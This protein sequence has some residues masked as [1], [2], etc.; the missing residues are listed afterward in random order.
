MERLIEW[1]PKTVPEDDQT[2]I[3]HADYRLDNMVMHATEPRVA[4]VLDWELATLGNPLADFTYVLMQ[5]VNGT[6]ATIPDLEAHGI[7]TMEEYVA[8]YCRLTGRSGLPDLNWYFAY[9]GFRLAGILQG[10][11]GRVRDGTANSPQ[12]AL[13]AA[14]VPALAETAWKYAQLAGA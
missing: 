5:W 11:V 1:L 6:L 3:V 10:I 13:Q 2:T 8:E 14:R 4:A 7:P 9:N 12:A